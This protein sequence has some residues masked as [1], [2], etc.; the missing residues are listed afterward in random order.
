MI[1][2]LVP[3]SILILSKFFGPPTNAQVSC[4]RNNIKIYIKIVPTFFRCRT[5]HLQGVHY[6]CLLKLHFVKI[7]NYGTSVYG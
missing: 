3:C 6:P 2:T 5:H 1:F 4:L 7:A